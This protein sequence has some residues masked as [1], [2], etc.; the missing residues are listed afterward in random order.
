MNFMRF[1]ISKRKNFQTI[2][3]KFP[4]HIQHLKMFYLKDPFFLFYPNKVFY[5]TI[6]YKEHIQIFQ[7]EMN[8]AFMNWVRAFLIYIC[9][10]L[11]SR[12]KLLDSFKERKLSMVR[13][14][15]L[16]I[17]SRYSSDWNFRSGNFLVGKLCVLYFLTGSVMRVVKS[18][19]VKIAEYLLSICL[20]LMLN[21]ITTRHNFIR[22]ECPHIHFYIILLWPVKIPFSLV[23]VIVL[24][25]SHGLLLK[26]YL[27]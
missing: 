19:K 24:Y 16:T 20:L 4:Y 6:L 25:W 13:K 8:F 18:T 14:S 10:I 27:G 22:L 26:D 9:N 11:V 7:L 1:K 12:L 2:M 5:C 15:N 17:C 21:K 23:T 3:P